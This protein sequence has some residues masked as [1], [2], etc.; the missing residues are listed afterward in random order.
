[1][2]KREKKCKILNIKATAIVHICIITVKLVHKYTILHP[3][4]WVFLGQNV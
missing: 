1:M 4:I 3:L 2:K